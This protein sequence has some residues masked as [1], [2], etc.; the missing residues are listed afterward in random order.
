MSG[1]DGISLTAEA[2]IDERFSLR[3]Y[4]HRDLPVSSL[5][6]GFAIARRGQGQV[7]LESRAYIHGDD[8][9][10]VDRGAT[11]R[12]GTLHVRTFHEE[13]D[14]ISFLVADFR[15]GMLWGMQ[16]AFRSVAAAHA[17]AWL[18]WRTVESGG[19]V[20]LMAITAGEPAIV[21]VRGGTRGM[22][23]VIG[24]LVR[25][26]ETALM[27]ARAGR[28]SKAAFADPPLDASLAGLHRIVPRGASVLIASSLDN[29]GPGFAEATGQLAR[30]ST[31][32]FL[33]IED[34]ALHALPDG[35][36]PLRAPDGTRRSG[37]FHQPRDGSDTANMVAGFDVL[38][39]DAGVPA[40]N[41]L[42]QAGA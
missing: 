3:Q 27:L 13:R 36:Y 15:P 37:R 30:R 41:A 14:R 25:A 5:P 31:P 17:L 21:R 42:L 24:G 35:H 26:H 6:G 22:L 4:A 16:R 1:G 2:L 38:R 23:A 29:T 32:R 8:I 18:G 11:A 33:L 12:T 19:R 34:A 9:R 39:V 28:G 20:G 10:H 7:V 40:R